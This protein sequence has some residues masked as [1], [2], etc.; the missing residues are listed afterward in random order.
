MADGLRERKK[1]ETRIA[2]SWAAVRLAVE[3]G[4]GNVRIEDIAAEAG[5]S[6]RTF[7]NY[8]DSKADAIAAREVDRSLRIAEELR[9]RPAAEPLWVAIRAAIEK[10]F[11]LGEEGHGGQRPPD[12][13]WLAGI[14]LMMTEPA[15]QGAVVRAYARAGEELA[16]A[17]ADRTGTSGLY[18]RLVAEV[19]GATRTVV[20]GEWL[21][22]DPP[23]SVADL[24]ASALD[25][26]EAGLPV[27]E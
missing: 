16:A 5:V 15:L 24:L 13:K 19:I 6:L 17:I 1:Q 4:Y 8:F 10:H 18:P 20:I 27:P 23:R 25:Q 3:R 26:I 12:D 21:R 11:A 7:R 14:R 9:D 2:L 22:A